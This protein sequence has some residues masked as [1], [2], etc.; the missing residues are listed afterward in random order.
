MERVVIVALTLM[1]KSSHVDP[2]SPQ[3]MQLKTIFR[4]IASPQQLRQNTEQNKTVKSFL[5]LFIIIVY[6]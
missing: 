3:S 2:C 5:L 6:C 4:A 1:I